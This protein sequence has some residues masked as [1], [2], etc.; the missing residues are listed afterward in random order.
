MSHRGRLVNGVK[1][2]ARC[3][4]PVCDPEQKLVKAARAAAAQPQAPALA[5]PIAAARWSA[6]RRPPPATHDPRTPRLR[7]LLRQGV[8][9]LRAFEIIDAEGRHEP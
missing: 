3:A 1:H 2:G 5:A 8:P 6:A 4:C 7:E 9:L